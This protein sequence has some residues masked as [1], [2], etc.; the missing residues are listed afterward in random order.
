M[1]SLLVGLCPATQ[2]QQ[3]PLATPSAGPVTL[4]QNVR[5]FDGKKGALSGPTNV[6]VR[7]NRI[8]RISTAAIPTD[9]SATTVL[10]DGG[11]RTLMP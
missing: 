1:A 6:L 2:A 3:A 8:E 10:I 9:R 7:G 5:V 4:F 11:G